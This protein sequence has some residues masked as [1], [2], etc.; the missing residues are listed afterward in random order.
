MHPPGDIHLRTSH[1][2]SVICM[3]Y[4]AKDVKKSEES[5]AKLREQVVEILRDNCRGS[6]DNLEA[7]RSSLTRILEDAT[8]DLE[9][10]RNHMKPT[11]P[12]PII[13]SGEHTIFV[14][15]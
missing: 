4:T 11:Q 5:L 15:K 7:M 13:I 8:K 9:Y 3:I 1:S 2:L 14:H 10:A 6:P 12:I